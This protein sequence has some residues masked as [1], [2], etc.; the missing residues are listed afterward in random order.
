MN[1]LTEWQGP[2]QNEKKMWILNLIFFHHRT[3]PLQAASQ[4]EVIV[5][6]TINTPWLKL[7]TMFNRRRLSLLHLHS[8]CGCDYTCDQ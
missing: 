4:M 2:K 3:R 8:K 5:K 6:F 1:E 7:Q